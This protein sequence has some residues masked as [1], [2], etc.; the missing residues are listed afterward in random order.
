MPCYIKDGKDGRMFICGDLG[1]HCDEC[2]WAA[3]FLCDFPVGEGKTC[4][5][6]LCDSHANEIGPD[7]HYCAAHAAMW[8]AYKESGGLSKDLENVFAFKK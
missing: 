7:L 4:D 1:P 3:D 6:N 5:R 8:N 2:S